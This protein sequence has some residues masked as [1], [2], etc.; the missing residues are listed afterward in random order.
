MIVWYARSL[1][2]YIEMI[3]YISGKQG[4]G[5]R[6]YPLW[7]RGNEQTD[8]YYYLDPGIYRDFYTKKEKNQFADSNNYG[9]LWLKE[10]YRFQHFV[11]RNYDKVSAMPESYIEWQEVMQHYFSKTRLMDWSESAIVALS[12]A[13]EAYIN[14]MEDHEVSYKR[15]HNSPV[16]WVLNPVKLNRKVYECFKGKDGIDLVKNAV[17]GIRK[18]N[19]YEIC[20]MLKEHEELYFL[21]D[22]NVNGGVNG[23]VSL[24]GLEA[25]RKSKGGNLNEALE[26]GNLNP[27]FFL[28]LKYYSEGVKV[29]I[30]KLPPL[31]IIHPQHSTRI[32]EQKGAFTIFPYYRDNTD[33]YL[34]GK[35][36]PYAM[37]YM[38]C[39]DCLEE[40]ILADAWSIADELRDI[41]VRR[42]HLYPEME[43]VTKDFENRRC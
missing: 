34:K 5:S 30:G 20:H 29:D 16:V 19:A 3:G 39:Q 6:K 7:F 26:V 13:L 25:L 37:E 22:N 9:T 32:H 10:E 4:D 12:F 35:I 41:G 40:I 18:Y 33:E 23:L 21:L 11:A 31:A 24:S 43:N 2:E 1:P 38:N 8:V 36:S 14:P 28:L 42:S 27:F 15:R 17:N